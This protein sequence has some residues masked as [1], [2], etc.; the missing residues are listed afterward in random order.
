[1][2]VYRRLTIGEEEDLPSFYNKVTERLGN[3]SQVN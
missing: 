2:K 3:P 1:M